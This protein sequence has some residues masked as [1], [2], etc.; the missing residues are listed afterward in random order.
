MGTG[1]LIANGNKLA[2]SKKFTHVCTTLMDKVEQRHGTK[3]KPIVSIWFFENLNLKMY[4]FCTL[5]DDHEKKSEWIRTE[6]R[7]Q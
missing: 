7:L 6:C 2:E 5:L 3:L 1:H 4:D